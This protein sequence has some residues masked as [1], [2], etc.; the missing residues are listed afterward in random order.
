[1]FSKSNA[2]WIFKFIFPYFILVSVTWLCHILKRVCNIIA[3]KVP[4]CCLSHFP[5]HAAKCKLMFNSWWYTVHSPLTFPL[6]SS[7]D[8]LHSVIVKLVSDVWRE[9]AC[10]LAERLFSSAHLNQSRYQLMR[11]KSHHLCESFFTLSNSF[12]QNALIQ[13]VNAPLS[14]NTQGALCACQ[15]HIGIS[16]IMLIVRYKTCMTCRLTH[17]SCTSDNLM[18]A[19]IQTIDSEVKDR[20]KHVNSW[21]HKEG[22]FGFWSLVTKISNLYLT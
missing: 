2:D 10:H 15:L 6:L 17:G 9:A 14:K 3:L 12:R 4:Q 13:T 19:S 16:V 21:T 8:V 7:L 5:K 22:S 1:M 20:Y 11:L 18:L